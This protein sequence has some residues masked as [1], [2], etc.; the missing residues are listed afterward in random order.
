MAETVIAS[1]DSNLAVRLQSVALQSEI[2]RQ[3]VF[4]TM[5]AGRQ[6]AERAAIAK[7]QRVQS[8][9]DMPIVIIT[10]LQQMA[11]DKVTTDM[12]RIVSGKPV[13]GD[14]KMEG[15]G[16]PLRFSSMEVMINQSRF[17]MDA[18]SRMTNKRTKHN[19]RAI[20]RAN[21]SNYFARLNDQVIQVH[22]AGSRGHENTEDWNVPLATDPDYAE[23][24]INPVMAPTRN[25]RFLAGGG[26]TVTDLDATDALKL[27]D[28]DTITAKLRELPF[29]PAPIKVEMDEMAQETPIW[30]LM[31]TERQWHYLL[32][33]GGDNNVRK[34]QAD[35]LI[36]ARAA[37]MHPLFRGDTLLWNSLLIKRMPRAIRF[38]EGQSIK[39]TQANGTE[40]D[41]TVAA[42]AGYT[43]SYLWTVDRA[44]LLGGQA[45]ALA[46][47]DAGGGNMGA[48]PTR[49]TEVLTD[50]GNSLEIGAGQIDGKMKF[51]YTGSD[52]ET[53][54]FGCAT[55]DSYAPDP[56][57]AEGAALRTALAT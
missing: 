22:L 44:I 51:R 39:E 2:T 1:S 42:P 24:M 5:M 54:D 48:F 10:D 26:A 3:S 14:R 57:S 18:G 47:G 55:I 36:R 19:I 23:I 25:R 41:V 8:T 33:R 28:L 40:S 32:V 46:R 6:P 17:P 27:E 12:F 50:H 7:R 21:M 20:V 13:M 53:T 15:R 35:A 4:A 56:S 16:A 45:L 11:G 30:C 43:G 29:P 31:I 52:G 38:L 37:K 34:W 49:W 9:P